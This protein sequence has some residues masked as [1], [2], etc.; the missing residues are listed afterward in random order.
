MT[1]SESMK[2]Y[3]SYVHQHARDTGLP[4]REARADLKGK[5]LPSTKETHF[6]PDRYY[7]KVRVKRH[8]DK[9]VTVRSDEF[10][11]PEQIKTEAAKFFNSHKEDYGEDDG[12]FWNEDDFSVRTCSSA[13]PFFDDEDEGEGAYGE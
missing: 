10:L 4:V 9:T 2:R 12:K 5:I 11:D 6:F 13:T 7:Y 8:K 1:R 3:W